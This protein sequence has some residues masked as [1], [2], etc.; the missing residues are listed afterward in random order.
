[1]QY[2]T[3]TIDSNENTLPSQNNTLFWT[4]SFAYEKNAV[5]FYEGA[6]YKAIRWT[7]AEVPSSNDSGPWIPFSHAIKKSIENVT[8]Y[9]DEKLPFCGSGQEE[10]GFTYFKYQEDVESVLAELDFSKIKASNMAEDKIVSNLALPIHGAKGISL[11][12]E[13]NL[14]DVLSNTGEVI[15]PEGEK[16]VPIWL[17]VTASKGSVSVLKIFELWIKAKNSPIVLNEEESVQLALEELSFKDFKGKNTKPTK[18]KDDLDFCEQGPHGTKLSWLC[19]EK[20]YVDTKGRID[21]SHLP[22]DRAL[23]LYV[24]VSKGNAQ[25]HKG[26]D[27]TVCKI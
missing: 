7:I 21:V 18:I 15:Q 19:M 3:Q 22:A 17:S 9:Y 12:W 10:D 27:I 20:K 5:V 4:S 14:Q 8:A 6:Y 24:L 16:D 1:M 25:A 26:F 13:S 23:K 11:R 2:Q